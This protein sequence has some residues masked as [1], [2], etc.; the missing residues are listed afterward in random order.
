LT[1]RDVGYAYLWVRPPV[2]Y[3]GHRHIAFID[4]ADITLKR[5]LGKGLAWAKLSASRAD[6]KIRSDSIGTVTPYL[7]LS[8]AARADIN[9][10]VHPDSGVSSLSRSDLINI[11]N[12][13]L[14][15]PADHQRL[16]PLELAEGEDRP[17]TRGAA[18]QRAGRNWP[19]GG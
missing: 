8:G 13:P 3:Y 16:P 14:R 10:V 17:E 11:F 9:I 12:R 7:T 19:A 5:P 18:R 4:G 1:T 2:D 15:H 6:E